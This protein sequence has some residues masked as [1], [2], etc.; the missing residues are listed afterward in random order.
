VRDARGGRPPPRDAG[1]D[2]P[3]RVPDRLDSEDRLP[4]DTAPPRAERE[5]PAAAT[6]PEIDIAAIRVGHRHRKDMGDIGALA[7]SIADIGLLQPIVVTPDNRLIAGERRLR[8]AEELGWTEIA[9]RMIDIDAVVKGEFTENALRKDFT[10]SELVA[11]GREIE[12]IERERAR[13]R[14]AHDGRPGKL[15]ER[16]RGDSRDKIAAQLGISG[17]TYEK[18]RAV[19]EAAESEP[20]SYG[21][22]VDE[23]DRYRGVD[24][25]YRALHCARD[26]ARVLGL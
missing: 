23:L 11:I 10:P 12:R 18:A 5:T 15:P 19:V 21:H 13:A 2:L 1:R 20:Q 26:Q 25:A 24:R 7:A 22:L 17:R 6:A 14:K 4:G 9:V 3:E 8:A 16:Q